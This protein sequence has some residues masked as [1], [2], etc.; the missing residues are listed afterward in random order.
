MQMNTRVK[1]IQ[2]LNPGGPDYKHNIRKS[3]ESKVSN[4]DWATL[5]VQSFWGL[6]MFV[7]TSL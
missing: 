7:S 4:R 3:E 2:Q 1:E 6:N 5:M